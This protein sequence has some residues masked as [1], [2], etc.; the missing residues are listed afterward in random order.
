MLII[1]KLA[2]T[3][4]KLLIYSVIVNPFRAISSRVLESAV[5]RLDR[6]LIKRHGVG[7][8]L[9]LKPISDGVEYRNSDFGITV[10]GK[11]VD[12]N[13]LH[14][15]LIRLRKLCPDSPI[16]LSTYRND[17]TQ[18]TRELCGSQGIVVVE[19]P[20]L[21]ELPPPFHA[22]LARSVASAFYGISEVQ[23]MGATWAMKLRVDQEIT[24]IKGVKFV[25][26]L[27]QGNILSGANSNRVIGTS[28]NS[29]KNLPLFLSDMLHFGDIQTLLKYWDLLEPGDFEILT[30]SIYSGADGLLLRL[31]IHPE[32]W[33]SSRY[34]RTM[35]QSLHDSEDAN[36]RFWNEYAGVVDAV[37]L[38]QN[39]VKSLNAFDSNYESTKW[40]GHPLGLRNLEL[41]FADWAVQ[42]LT[43]NTN[44]KE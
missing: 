15:S 26:G 2:P 37:S 5:A 20:E 14:T 21:D 41:R 44:I 4:L 42:V 3:R 25:E 33:L 11:I 7:L 27:L 39:W 8:S 10:H 36:L 31:N 16:V 19:C 22:N 18:E 23:K 12:N 6:H 40:L 24:Q 30:Q 38:G 35:G 32:V 17:L 29:F 43:T 1:R 34:M 28:Y 9:S 13:F